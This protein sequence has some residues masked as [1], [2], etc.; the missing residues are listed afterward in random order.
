V[1]QCKGPIPVAARS[2]AARLW[3][4]WLPIPLETWMFPLV[5]VMCCTSTGHGDEPIPRPESPTGCDQI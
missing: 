5:N 4:L 1:A 3:E 2:A